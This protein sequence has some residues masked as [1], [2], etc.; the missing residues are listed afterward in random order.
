MTCLNIIY[1]PGVGYKADG[2]L[3]S[4]GVGTVSEACALSK[5][6]LI[7]GLGEKPGGSCGVCCGG[8]CIC[9]AR[10]VAWGTVALELQY[11]FQVWSL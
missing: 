11:A 5:Q 6:Q 8:I 10:V 9:L 1:T 3:K 4:W 7:Q 2:L